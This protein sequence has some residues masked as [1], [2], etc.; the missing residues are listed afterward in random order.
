MSEREKLEAQLGNFRKTIAIGEAHILDLQAR[1]DALPPEPDLSE[2]VKAYCANRGLCFEINERS[3]SLGLRAAYPA[4]RKAYGHD[5]QTCN[6]CDRP[7]W[8][9]ENKL[10]KMA[11]EVRK[12]AYSEGMPGPYTCPEDAALEM[13]R[14]IREWQEANNG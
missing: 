3:V 2:A 13:A 6:G 10:Q 4:L 11:N 7:A 5:K 12:W 1:L 9:D 8:P 14:R